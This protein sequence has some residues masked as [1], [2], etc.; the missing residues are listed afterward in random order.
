MNKSKIYLKILKKPTN[1]INLLLSIL[2][3]YFGYN[4][5]AIFLL[6]INILFI[7]RL[8]NSKYYQA[9]TKYLEE[10]ELEE[11][12]K[13]NNT[14]AHLPY[15]I[16]VKID[17]LKNTS[18][19]IFIGLTKRNEEFLYV[20]EQRKNMNKII[21]KYALLQESYFEYN[22]FLKDKK[23][24]LEKINFEIYY[25]EKK[26]QED[27]N[28]EK[29]TLKQNI[30]LL[31]ERK[32]LL[33]KSTNILEQIELQIKVIENLFH[34]TAEKIMYN[35]SIKDFSEEINK[36]INNSEKIEDVMI[37]TRK[38]MSSFNLDII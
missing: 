32:E 17:K 29:E 16:K 10:R 8:A 9:Y 4:L 7:F 12:N 14:Y 30:S 19:D 27:S 1:I 22:K 6:V 23:D 36:L 24:A 34:L 26:L 2:L 38:E 35:S 5:A 33:E 20:D 25:Q 11:Q 21:D 31:K 3:F 13:S 37:K 28:T 15:E 18:Y